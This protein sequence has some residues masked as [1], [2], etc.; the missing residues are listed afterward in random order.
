MKYQARHYI[1]GIQSCAGCAN[2]YQHYVY[3]ANELHSTH[4]GHCVFPRMK[5]RYTTDACEHF[6]ERSIP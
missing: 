2:F 1:K 3:Y 6:A 4:L 5:A